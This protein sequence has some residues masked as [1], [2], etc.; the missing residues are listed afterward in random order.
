MM[1]ISCGFFSGGRPA[2]NCTMV[3]QSN[4]SIVAS[5]PTFFKSA[6]TASASSTP[7]G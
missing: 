4:T 6:A 7:I 3:A 5:M 2:Q 1:K